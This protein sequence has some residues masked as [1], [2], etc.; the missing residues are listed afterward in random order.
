MKN[1]TLQ[2]AASLFGVELGKIREWISRGYIDPAIPA[3]GR[4]VPNLLSKENLYQISLFNKLLT[5]GLSRITA[6]PIVG[7]MGFK[8]TYGTIGMSEEFIL[9]IN[10]K[11]I[12]TETDKLIAGFINERG[13]L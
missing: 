1:Y 10:L 12:K 4:G 5:V 9:N 11:K 6:A 8:A 3:T 2:E 13:S 7:L